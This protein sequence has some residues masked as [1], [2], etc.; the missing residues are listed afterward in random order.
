MQTSDKIAFGALLV[1]V[2]SI[3]VAVT[4]VMNKSTYD[5]DSIK[6]ALGD[7]NVPSGLYAQIDNAKRD[8]LEAKTLSQGNKGTAN[9][10]RSIAQL[11]EK[12]AISAEKDA[13][14]ALSKINGSEVLSK[15]AEASA[16]VAEVTAQAAKR[17]SEMALLNSVPIGTILPWIPTDK[18]KNVPKGWKVCDGT[19]G[20]PDLEG[21]FLMGVRHLNK[22][23]QKGGRGDIPAQGAHSHG[24]ATTSVNSARIT[25]SHGGDNNGVW[26]NHSHGIK[27]EGNHN[28]GGEN[29]PPYFTVIY[30]IKT[31]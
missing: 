17:G 5:L 15:K 3:I 30:I 11:A 26:F 2:I 19:N 24:G 21:R 4:T 18:M 25:Y 9:E 22:T 12:T 16:K 8:S 29:K 6:S 28:H 31:S 14:A 7:P 10:S 23:Q 13:Q 1:S 20:A 27:N